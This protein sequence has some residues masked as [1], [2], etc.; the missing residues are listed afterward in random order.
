MGDGRSRIRACPGPGSGRGASPSSRTCPGSPYRFT[1]THFI[2][3][4]LPGTDPAPRP[5]ISCEGPF[6]RGNFTR[7]PSRTTVRLPPRGPQTDGDVMR[8]TKKLFLVGVALSLATAACGS[9]SQ[10]KDAV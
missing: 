4:S 6:A 7:R 5:K 8:N 10:D 1:T 3:L 2:E 9:S